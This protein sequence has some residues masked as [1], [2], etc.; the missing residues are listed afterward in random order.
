[1]SGVREYHRVADHSSVEAIQFT[2][3]NR[4]LVEQWLASY[5]VPLPPFDPKDWIVL[6]GS[7]ALVC[8]DQWFRLNYE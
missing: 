3:E 5:A 8:S 7:N 4:S 1:M 6:E 2:G